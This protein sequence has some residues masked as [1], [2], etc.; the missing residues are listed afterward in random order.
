GVAWLALW[1]LVARPPFLPKVEAK[2]AKLSLPN[3]GARRVWA[4][5]FSYGLTC[6]A[7]GPIVT[8][9][10]LYL[11]TGLGVSQKDIGNLVWMPALAWG[12][13]YFFWGWIVDRYAHNNR[14]PIGLFALLTACA[15][16]LGLP[17]LTSSVA[18][19]MAI[20]SW[21]TFIGGGFQM[22]ALKVGS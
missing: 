16:V 20:M 18:M 3:F 7:P 10:S 11:S 14:R 6:I 17:T 19:T 13:G 15:L 2:T 1:A 9:L 5:I 4:L 12:I 21:A 22:L 8:L